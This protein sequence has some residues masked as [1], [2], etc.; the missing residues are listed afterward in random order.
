M[1]FIDISCYTNHALD[2]FLEHLLPI[3]KRIVRMGSMSKSEKL[4]KYNLYE[5]VNRDDGT[6]TRAEGR[7]EYDCHNAMELQLKDGNELCDSL[8]HGTSKIQWNQLDAFLNRNYPA[9]HAQLMGGVDHDGFVKVGKKRGT[10]FYYW[11]FSLDLRDRESY[12]KLHGNITDNGPTSSSRPLTELLSSNADIWEFSRDERTLILRHWDDRLRQDWIDE[13]VVRA[14]GYQDESEKLVAVRSE[15]YRRL[16]ER[17]DVIG[18]TTTGLARYAPLLD[19]IESKTL[20]CE[21]AGE[22]LEATPYQNH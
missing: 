13:I 9:H 4:D 6:K 15:C 21:E 22:V 10:Y 7:M 11:K 17:V 3:T 8:C 5:W 19:R 2:Q 16:L 14:Q 1:S 20:I 18:L 12:E